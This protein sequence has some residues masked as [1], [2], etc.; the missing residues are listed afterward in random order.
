MESV[1]VSNTKCY[2]S[3]II[4]TVIL[5]WK[6][7]H[8][9]GSLNPLKHFFWGNKCILNKGYRLHFNMPTLCTLLHLHLVTPLTAYYFIMAYFAEMDQIGHVV[10]Y[11]FV[12]KVGKSFNLTFNTTDIILILI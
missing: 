9:C 5:E 11:A 3:K 1:F 12:L 4:C 10:C 6:K 8:H 2:H 7:M